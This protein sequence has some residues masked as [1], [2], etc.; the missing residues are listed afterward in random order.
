[1]HFHLL[2]GSPRFPGAWQSAHSHPLQ[3]WCLF[4]SF[5]HCP[6]LPI[7]LVTP[8]TVFHSYQSWYVCLLHPAVATGEKKPCGP[9]HGH[10]YTCVSSLAIP[11][12]S[13]GCLWNEQMP[14]LNATGSGVIHTPCWPHHLKFSVSI[15]SSAIR[16]CVSQGPPFPQLQGIFLSPPVVWQGAHLCQ[17]L[18]L[19]ESTYGSSAILHPVGAWEHSVAPPSWPAQGVR[20][21]CSRPVRPLLRHSSSCWVAR[22][23]ALLPS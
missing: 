1:M 6:F 2:P 9:C 7:L 3:I 11:S 21:G 18:G 16:L 13:C 20:G 14:G 5:T 19:V 8:T 12:G 23:R 10:P 22:C 17:K 15:L 4:L